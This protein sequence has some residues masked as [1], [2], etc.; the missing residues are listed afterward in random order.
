MGPRPLWRGRALAL[1]GIVLV[2]ANLRTAVT[3][4][5]PIFAEID[6]DIGV[7]SV[8][9][10]LLGMLPPLCFALFGVF[11]PRLVRRLHLEPVLLIALGSIVAGHLMRSLAPD[12]AVLAIGSALCFAGIGIGNVV[13]PPLVK[14]YFPDRVGLVTSLY[15]TVLSVSTFIPPLIAVP[16]ADAAGWQVSLG[17]WSIVA[18]LAV[19]P[20]IALIVRER[21]DARAAAATDPEIEEVPR[22][23]RVLVHRSPI[24]WA[25]AAV[26][27]TS[28][29]NAYAMFT[30]LPTIVGDVAGVTPAQGGLLLSLF[31]AMGVPASLIV[32]M[33]VARLRN[34]AVLVYVASACFV[35]GYLGLLLWPATLTWL[36]V[37]LA[38]LGPLLFPL[39]LVLIN[40]RTAT[41][42]GAVAL[43][44]FVQ[45]VGYTLGALGPLVV[46]LLHAVTGS[47]TV[48]LL[49]L[50]ATGALCAIAGR[51]TGRPTTI[52]A[53]LAARGR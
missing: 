4:L 39:A 44:G 51:I 34:V 47:W 27:A 49:L 18:M 37:L 19:L 20:W 23:G 24:A 21:R 31:S 6:G 52:E 25:I 10:G 12:F 15:A 32:P 22:A 28:S 16:V 42:E 2:A 40:L 48:P 29:L 26:F 50:L 43:S 7:G 38:G 8:G 33:L 53:D 3:S 41:H 30:W 11:T 9:L 17:V 5:S 13:L 36:W 14:K 46:S 1:V 35:L 45:S